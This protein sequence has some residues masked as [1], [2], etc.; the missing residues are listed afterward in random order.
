MKLVQ[1]MA[2]H[3][4]L[5]FILASEYDPYH[6]GQRIE[7]DRSNPRYL[8]FS[9]DHRYV[10]HNRRERHPGY[11][12]IDVKQGRLTIRKGPQSQRGNHSTEVF[13]IRSFDG[14]RLVLLWQGRHGYVLRN[15]RLV[16]KGKGEKLS[17]R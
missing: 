15:Y 13:T 8:S 17:D 3:G 4:Q 14:E 10:Y 1:R 7:A 16:R 11:W 2:E 9:S 6:R 5:H 12:H